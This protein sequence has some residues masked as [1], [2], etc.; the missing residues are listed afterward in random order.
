METKGLLKLSYVPK[1]SPMTYQN[2]FVHLISMKNSHK[3]IILDNFVFLFSIK[4]GYFIIKNAL[5]HF[6]KLHYFTCSFHQ[7]V[8]FDIIMSVTIRE[9]VL[10]Y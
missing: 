4:R 9:F 5:D 3:L 2:V 10:V 1:F 6:V 7:V 8:Q